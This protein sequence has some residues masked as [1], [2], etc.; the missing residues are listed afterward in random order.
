M[1]KKQQKNG[2]CLMCGKPLSGRIGKKFCNQQCK[3]AWH[4]LKTKDFR[5]YH[6]R[7]ITALN[8]NY[9]LLEKALREGVMSIDLMLLENQGFRPAYMTSYTTVRYGNDICRCFDISY[10]R[11][12]TR[13]FKIK[14]DPLTTSSQEPALQRPERE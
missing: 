2:K 1:T 3:N 5:M 7:I 14:R 8:R 6:N 12:G 4:N 10:C 11:S 13:I 9:S